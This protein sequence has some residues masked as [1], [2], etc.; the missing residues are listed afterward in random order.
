M[1]YMDMTSWNAEAW[2]QEARAEAQRS[3]EQYRKMGNHLINNYMNFMPGVSREEIVRRLQR[4]NAK[5]LGA[6]PDPARYPELRGMRDMVEALWRGQRDGA[7]MDDAQW[8]AYCDGNFYFHRE[9]KGGM[10]HGC[11]YVFFPTSDRGPI[12]ANNLDSSPEEP[13]AEPVLPM[14]NEHVLTGGVSSGV[15]LDE[16]SPEIFPAP[17]YKLV[18]HFC[19]TAKEA[20]AM[21]TQ[22]NHFWGPGNVLV[23]DRGRNAAMVEKSACRIGVRWSGDGFAY[24]TAM[25]AEEPSMHAFLA[26]RRAASVKARNLPEDC[27]DNA[28][29]READHRHALMKELIG[30]AKS[31]P[32]LEGLRR[33]IQFRDPV[34]GKVCYNGE[35]LMPGGPPCEHTIRTTLFILREGRALW[36]ARE[37]DR[38]SFTNKPREAVYPDAVHWE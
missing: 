25:T 28:Y 27:I 30:E 13:F 7:Q 31:H 14:V 34:R 3:A 18:G 2:Y 32:T 35:A 21:M 17:V 20:V 19:R 10:V 12:L 38:P 1:K 29:W 16:D 9:L 22:Y 11:S 37:G 6:A 4:S 15:F 8:A 26:G 5:R 36:W 24:V 23:L 33:I